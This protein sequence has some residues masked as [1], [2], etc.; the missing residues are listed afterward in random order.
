MTTRRVPREPRTVAAPASIA[1]ERLEKFSDGD[2]ADLCDAT[3]DAIE[4]GGGF[5]WLTPPM[6]HVLESYWQGVLLVP[7][8][9][10]FVG[11]LDGV[12]AGSAQLLHPPKNNEAQAFA[13]QM[14]TSFV[15]PWARGHGL[16]RGL[17]A[18]IE[19]E[20]VDCGYQ[21]LK[22]DVRETQ[23][24]AIALYESRGYVRWGV[25]PYY[26]RVDDKVIRGFHYYKTL[27]AGL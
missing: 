19:Q 8:R 25:D 11:R 17:L 4:A 26:A 13:A 9:E 18:A 16:A 21:L 6:P 27:A 15:A 20:A 5:G 3:S 24:V 23:T 10:L 7:G 1:V 14:T 12:I 2:L 22:L